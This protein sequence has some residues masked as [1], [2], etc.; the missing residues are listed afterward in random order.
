M[1]IFSE[2][3]LRIKFKCGIH[4]FSKEF[5]QLCDL[6]SHSK[7]CILCASSIWQFNERCKIKKKSHFFCQSQ[8]SCLKLFF[9]VFCCTV[10]IPYKKSYEFFF[11]LY[12][13]FTELQKLWLIIFLRFR[14]Q[15][16]KSLVSP[17]LPLSLVFL[18]RIKSSYDSH[19]SKV[20]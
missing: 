20:R 13:V 7:I 15:N 4:N 10:K 1:N 5:K 8:N 19:L 2:M 6:F 14:H 17:A 9:F 16:L 11:L 12:K 18:G 3:C